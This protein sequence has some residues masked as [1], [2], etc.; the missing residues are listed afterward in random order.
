LASIHLNVSPPAGAASANASVA[1]NPAH[2][3]RQTIMPK[4][5]RREF[6]FMP[7]SN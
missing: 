7:T 4:P 3:M 1:A 2:P 6:K 5:L